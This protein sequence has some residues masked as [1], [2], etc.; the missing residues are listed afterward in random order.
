[1]FWWILV[2]DKDGDYS[3]LGRPYNSYSQAQRVADRLDVVGYEIEKL[4]TLNA[5]KATRLFK[6]LMAEKEP[7]KFRKFKR[8]K[9]KKVEESS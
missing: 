1:M 3:L 8:F 9:H 2:W 4:P 5:A 7:E 6:G